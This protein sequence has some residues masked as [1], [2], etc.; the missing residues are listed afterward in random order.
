MLYVVFAVLAGFSIIVS[1][2]LNANM[3]LRIGIF[4]GTFMNYV[5][6]LALSLLLVLFAPQ[7]FRLDSNVSYWAFLGGPMG[8]AV[9]GLSSYVT[10]RVSNFNITLLTFIGQLVTGGAIDLFL[11]KTISAT[12]LAGGAL[13][14]IGLIYYILVDRNENLE[15]SRA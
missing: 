7:D 2:I 6:G 11:G 1:R 13:I 10:H 14:I 12:K 8:V 5:V 9:I 15:K 3:A 4:Q